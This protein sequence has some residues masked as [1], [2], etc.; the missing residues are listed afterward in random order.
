[1]RT[2]FVKLTP[3]FAS[4]E[5]W[6]QPFYEVK[7]RVQKFSIY[8]GQIPGKEKTASDW[9]LGVVYVRLTIL[10]LRLYNTSRENCFFWLNKRSANNLS[11]PQKQSKAKSWNACELF[12]KKSFL[13]KVNITVGCDNPCRALTPQLI[14]PAKRLN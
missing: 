5:I 1:M 12:H 8:N 2:L 10:R 6:N 9:R 14:F 7:I 11:F 13:I 3:I 4:L